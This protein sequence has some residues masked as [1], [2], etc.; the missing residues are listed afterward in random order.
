MKN[1]ILIIL[2]FI[3]FVANASGPSMPDGYRVPNEE[4]LSLAER[5]SDKY[6]Y[7]MAAG[8][9]NGDGLVDGAFLAIN[10]NKKEV[11][12][13]VFLCTDKDQVFKWYKLESFEYRTIKYTGVRLIKP[14]LIT[15][16]SDIKGETK[17]ELKIV[18]DSFELFQ[19]EGSSSIFYYK[20]PGRP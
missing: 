3:P 20:S 5:D 4:E 10:H 16:Y 8:D 18:N 13:F 12:L 2:L 14:Q 6:R 19:F 7:A 1:L 17:T 11:A 15:F 9:F